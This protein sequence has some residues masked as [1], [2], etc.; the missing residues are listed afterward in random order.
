[1]MWVR[2][3]ELSPEDRRTVLASFTYRM[4]VESVRQHPRATAQAKAGGY[5][6]P[7]ITDAVWLAHTDFAVTM[8]GRLDGRVRRCE[9]HDSEC[10][11]GPVL[12]PAE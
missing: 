8:S 12:P 7:L 9:H 2:G 4:T 6:L 5:R 3:T 10:R 11:V 1:M